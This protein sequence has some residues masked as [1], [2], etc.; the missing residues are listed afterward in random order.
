MSNTLNIIR[1]NS[2]KLVSEWIA[3]A[4]T[5]FNGWM[6]NKKDFMNFMPEPIWCPIP[7]DS[8]KHEFEIIFLN[9]NPGQGNDELSG[10]GKKYVKSWEKNEK[11]YSLLLQKDLLLV[12]PEFNKINTY[13]FNL[14]KKIKLFLNLFENI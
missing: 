9:I 10:R 14:N 5:S 8:S 13:A 2:D 3:K 7:D 4:E 1:T 11:K 12:G 6:I